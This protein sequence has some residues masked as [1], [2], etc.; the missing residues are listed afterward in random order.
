MLAHLSHQANREDYRFKRLFRNLYNP[1]FYKMFLTTSDEQYRNQL[2]S[3]ISKLQHGNYRP[4]DYVCRNCSD[5]LIAQCVEAILL[6]IY[7]KTTKETNLHK[8]IFTP[9]L[10]STWLFSGQIERQDKPINLNFLKKK[11]SDTKFLTLIKQLERA[12]YLRSLLLHLTC[13][14]VDGE[15]SRIFPEIAYVRVKDCILIGANCTKQMALS[16]QEVLMKMLEEKYGLRY[17]VKGKNIYHRKEP[18]PF[19]QYMLQLSLQTGD[20][21]F[22]IGKEAL[23]RQLRDW[24]VIRIGR[25]G[26]VISIHRPYLLNLSER[27]IIALYQREY[28]KI[29]SYYRYAS[30]RGLL[31]LCHQ[32]MRESMLKTLAYK[33][34]TTVKK[35]AKSLR[36]CRL[37]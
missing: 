19:R 1:L 5:Q 7:T 9:I 26:E 11:I 22:F 33:Y 14:D 29:T 36:N 3:L 2:P 28:R 16:Y 31:R 21:T 34:K 35:I 12:G 15:I 10:Q 27:D 23:I 24:H 20:V 17:N 4:N 30:N 6:A 37:E 25:R 8:R 32:Y 18:I 13:I